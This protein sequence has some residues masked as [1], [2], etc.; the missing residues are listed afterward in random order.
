MPMILELPIAMLA[1]ARIESLILLSLEALVLTPS[2]IDVKM[3]CRLIITA[4]AGYRR[5]EPSPLK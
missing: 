5:I 4:D 3:L 1:C 2:L